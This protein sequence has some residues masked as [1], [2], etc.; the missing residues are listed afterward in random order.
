MKI[1]F[2]VTEDWYFWSHRLPVA[3]AVRDMGAEVLVMTRLNHLEEALKREGFCVIPWRISRGSLNPFREIFVLL[4]VFRAYRRTRPDLVHHVALKPVVYGG[5]TSRLCEGIASVN[6][7]ACLGHVFTSRSHS[8]R[9]FR[10]LLLMLFWMALRGKSSRTIFQNRDDRDT[11]VEAGVVLPAHTVIIRGSGVN[12]REF[13]PRP[14]PKGVPV[15]VMACRML[16][17][18]GVAEFVHAA[19]RLREEGISARFVLVGDTD[20]GNRAAIPAAQLHAWSESGIVE[21]WGHRINMASL[22]TQVNL[23]CLPSYYGEGV[24]KVLLEAGACARAIVATDA[25]GC[26]EVVRHGENGLLVPVRDRE[27]LTRALATLLRNSAL[28][29]RMGARGREIVIQ[30]FSEEK[31]V[32][33][34]LSVYQEL[35]GSRCPNTP[36]MPPL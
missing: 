20:P 35:L 2:L 18:K 25:P 5:L 9:L 30:E 27:A 3:R 16:W 22:F 28:R 15:V 6:A 23:V 11:L 33:E 32:Q 12:H 17:N 7:I 31:V 29:A 34:T 1:L 8:M 10:R 24:P 26:R 13:L 14:E 36:Q 19:R 4:Q 21:W